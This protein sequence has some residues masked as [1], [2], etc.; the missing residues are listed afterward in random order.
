MSESKVDGNRLG[1]GVRPLQNPGMYGIFLD[2]NPKF[3]GKPAGPLDPE[4]IRYECYFNDELDIS[5]DGTQNAPLHGH[6]YH[7]P[8]RDAG[9]KR[10]R[11]TGGYTVMLKFNTSDGV[12]TAHLVIYLKDFVYTH[13]FDVKREFPVPIED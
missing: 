13:E 12:R 4:E 1:V 8:E 9:F 5:F 3:Q 2:N 6:H 11:E 7:L 10:L